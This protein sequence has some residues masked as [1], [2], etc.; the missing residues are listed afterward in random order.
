M[1]LP[2]ASPFAQRVI[3]GVGDMAVSNNGEMVLS[4]Y[5]LGSCIGVV[6]FDPVA[7]AGGMLHLMLP[8]SGIAR[9]RA[10]RQPA[11]FADTGLAMFFQSLG[12][13]H[14]E[15]DS[16]RLMVAGGASVLGGPDP[17]RIGE[18]NSRVTLEFLERR[19]YAVRNIVVGG[20]VNRALHLEMATGIVTLKTPQEEGYF[21]LAS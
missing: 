5:A 18:R 8:D 2:A 3:I 14:A 13:L 17:Y 12:S 15:H 10:A 11:L 6:A 9:D 4:T 20:G 19:G 16:L 7:R 21:S 1:A